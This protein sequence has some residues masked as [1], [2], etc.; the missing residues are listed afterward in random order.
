MA[1]IS[2]FFF[3][4]LRDDLPSASLAIFIMLRNKEIKLNVKTH[5][6]LPAVNLQYFIGCHV[7][8]LELRV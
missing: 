6:P 8:I 4:H 3:T 1:Q 2:F 5:F 7:D